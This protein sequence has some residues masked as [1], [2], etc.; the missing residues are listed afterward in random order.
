MVLMLQFI[1]IIIIIIIIL[2]YPISS[3]Q[4]ILFWIGSLHQFYIII[5]K[6]RH[7]ALTHSHIAMWLTRVILL[8]ASRIAL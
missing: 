8:K 4:V 2:K 3:I 6:S 5:P 1:I 7:S